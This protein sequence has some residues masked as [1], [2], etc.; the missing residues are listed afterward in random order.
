[1]S[2][3]SN[4]TSAQIVS[5]KRRQIF[6]K[7]LSRTGKVIVAARAAG[8]T[9]STYLYRVR[10]EDEEFAKQWDAALYASADLLEEAAWDRAVEGVEKPILFKGEVVATEVQYS[11]ALLIRLLE[12][13]RKSD[14][15]RQNTKLDLSIETNVRVGVAMIPM[16]VDPA[17][18]EQQA[19]GVH[20]RQRALP[21]FQEI[22]KTIDAESVEVVKKEE[23][24]SEVATQ[25]VLG[26][27]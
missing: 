7:H 25:R 1:M 13:R 23:P 6:L 19:V 9:N 3:D 17:S 5:R 11:D 18:W 20:D 15:Q 24:S 26:R 8:F 10:D 12:A 2:N 21:P 16:T 4:L 14:Y 27:A 22:G